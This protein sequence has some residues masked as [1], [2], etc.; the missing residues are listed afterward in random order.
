MFPPIP[1]SGQ[2]CHNGNLLGILVQFL[3]IN[4]DLAAASA[5]TMWFLA[6][7]RKL[8]LRR[9]W[10]NLYRVSESFSARLCRFL[11]SQIFFFVYS[12]AI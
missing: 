4:I 12:L 3:G 1:F 11:L 10:P 5:A 9:K 7:L 2:Y 6:E 8:L